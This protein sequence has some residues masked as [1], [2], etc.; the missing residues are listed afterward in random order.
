MRLNSSPPSNAIWAGWN[1]N[2]PAGLSTGIFGIHHPSGD[3]QKYSD[4]TIISYATCTEDSQGN[5]SC[6]PSNTIGNNTFYQVSWSHGITEPGSSGS[7]L[8]TTN[9]K[10]IIGQLYAGSS[11]CSNKTGTEFYGRLDLAYNAALSKWLNPDGS[12]GNP[13]PNAT[14]TPLYRFYNTVTYA[15]FYTN[16]VPER[17]YVIATYPSFKYEG[18]V[19]NVYNSP[20]AAVSAVYR[21]YN[22]KSWVHFYTINQAERD[23]VIATLPAMQYEGPVWY[24]QPSSGNGASA[25]YRFYSSATDAHFYTINLAERDYVLTYIPGFTYEGPVFYAW[26]IQ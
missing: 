21:F 9:G 11:S 13:P 19:Y 15:H 12:G 17:D 24:A 20:T 16:N 7:G 25:V 22:T 5:I 2:A 6:P 18:P 4:G 10:Q 23:W 14:L 1:A 26:P 8:F 3:L